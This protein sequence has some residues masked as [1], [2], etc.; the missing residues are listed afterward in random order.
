MKTK[1]IFTLIGIV[2][3]TGILSFWLSYSLMKG[4]NANKELEA[5]IKKVELKEA[6]DNNFNRS[7]EILLQRFDSLLDV[8]YG[9]TTNTLKQ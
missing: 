6:L 7:N 8:H 3:A 1:E 4:H 2:T 9:T 5:K